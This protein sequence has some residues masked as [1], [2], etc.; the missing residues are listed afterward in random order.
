VSLANA[1]PI[2]VLVAEDDPDDMFFLRRVLVKT[3]P[4]AHVTAFADGQ[5]AMD[6][7]KQSLAVEDR[8]RP[9]LAFLDIRMPGLTGLE[10]L[11]WIRSQRAFDRMAV[12]ILTSSVAVEDIAAADDNGAQCYSSKHLQEPD[13]RALLEA[14][15]AFSS[16]GRHTFDVPI[17]LLR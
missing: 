8:P 6:Y 13:A 5:S 2:V 12:I 9:S 16:G 7:L 15:E 17:N 4:G 3:A 14:A 1:K 10:L 11:Q